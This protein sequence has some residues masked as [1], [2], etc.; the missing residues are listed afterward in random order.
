MSRKAQRQAVGH[1][2]ERAVMIGG[3][4]TALPVTQSLGRLGIATHALGGR[5]DPVRDS[6]YC[7]SYAELEEGPGFQQAALESLSCSDESGVIMPASDDAVELVARNR[8]IL[9]DAG[10]YVYRADDAVTLAMLDKEQTYALADRIRIPAPRYMRLTSADDA[11]AAE[12]AFS[13]P[14][15]L[16]PLKS[17]EFKRRLGATGKVMIAHDRGEL[18]RLISLTVAHGVDM[19]AIEV[20]PGSDDQIYGYCTYIDQDGRPLFHFVERKLRQEPIRFGNG[21]YRIAEWHPQAAQ[22]GLRFCQEAGLRGV[23]HIEFRKDARDGELK[24]MECNNRFDLCTQLICSA[25]VTLPLMAYNEAVGLPTP[26]ASSPT[27]G[28]RVWHP[29]PDYRALRSYRSEGVLTTR[30]WLRSLLHRQRFTVFSWR[31]PVPSIALHWR[32]LTR[33]IKRRLHSTRLNRQLSTSAA[34][35]ARYQSLS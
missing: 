18:E 26:Q 4:P 23:A 16:K 7:C 31:D 19:L 5:E 29:L 12:R 35:D 1:V 9:E 21:S 14:C 28:V 27:Y 20:I 32:W 13:F 10:Y 8:K 11:A 24:L 15:C 2:R 17:H 22:L 6:R 34:D 30:A 3:G 33:L 25:G